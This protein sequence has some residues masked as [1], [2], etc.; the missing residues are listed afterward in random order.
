ML[1]KLDMKNAFDRVKIPFLY[2]VLLSLGFSLDFV[3]LIKA[4]TDRPWIAPLVNGRPAEFFKATR[5]L[6][7]GCPMS[8]FLY[9]LMVETLSRK[10]ST[11][12]EVG[13]IP[14][15][16]IARGVDPINHALFVDDSLLIGGASLK[17]A[18]AFNVILQNFNLIIGALINNNKTVVYG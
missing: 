5:R 1:I 4:C 13:Y 15:I 11:E 17:I 12:K 8:P 2:D 10:L 16:K 3:N 6:H 14:S 7:Q 18:W 9:I